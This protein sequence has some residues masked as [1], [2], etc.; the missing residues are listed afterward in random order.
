[1]EKIKD[2]NLIKIIGKGCFGQVYLAIKDNFEKYAIKR[3]H[4]SNLEKNLS[5]KK[6]I[7]NEI[8]IQYFSL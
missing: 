5:K 8:N 1:M 3:I 2:Y 4:I 7:D 6:C